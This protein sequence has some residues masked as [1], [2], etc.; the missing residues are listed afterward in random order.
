[1]G[2]RRVDLLRL[3]NRVVGDGGY[4]IVSD[5]KQ[6]KLA[7]RKMGVEFNL[8][9]ANLPALAFSLKSAYYKNLA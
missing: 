5:T 6:S 2:T 7:W 3:Y 4:D 1:M 9:T 8:G